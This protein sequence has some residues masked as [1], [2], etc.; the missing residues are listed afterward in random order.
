ME[1]TVTSWPYAERLRRRRTNIVRAGRRLLLLLV[2]C[3]PPAAALDGRL[4]VRYWDYRL[5]GDTTD[6]ERLDFQRDLAARTDDRVGFSLWLHPTT[7]WLPELGY[8]RSPLDVRGQ[9][10]RQSGLQIGDLTLLPQTR[11]A[12][13]DADL[14]NHSLTAR[15]AIAM[16]PTLHLLPGL[17]LRQIDGDV[18]IRDGDD[19]AVDDER[20]DEWFPQLH[21][22]LHW[23]PQ[24]A[25]ALNL[26]GEWIEASGRSADGLE[27]SV[28]WLPAGGP[29]AIE[30]GWALQRYRFSAGDDRVRARFAGPFAGLGVVW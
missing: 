6:S 13:V 20:I 1:T 25:L 22:A 2:A 7:G 30:A 28:R 26:T 12:L 8:R 14:D 19:I 18:R 10:T 29:L 27:A 23:Q 9:Q 5:E 24:P 17:T 21:L 16:S 11:E 15:Y 4:G 3:S